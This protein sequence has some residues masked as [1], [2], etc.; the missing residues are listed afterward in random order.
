MLPGFSGL[1]TEARVQRWPQGLA[2]AFPGRGR[3]QASLLRPLGRL[4]LA[5]DYLG[6]SYTDT[7]IQTGLGAAQDVLSQ[8][9]SPATRRPA[10]AA[11]AAS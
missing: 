3:L 1:V 8:L 10:V 2:Y 5:G 4:S 6:S 9:V 11:R 7:A